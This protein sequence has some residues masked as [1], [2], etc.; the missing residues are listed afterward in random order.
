MSVRTIESVPTRLSASRPGSTQRAQPMMRMEIGSPW[1]GRQSPCS[2]TEE[3]TFVAELEAASI[4]QV[5]DE[6]ERRDA[7]VLLTSLR[8]GLTLKMLLA[9]APGV[10]PD[11]LLAAHRE[12]DGRR[13]LAAHA[14]QTI[15]VD[16]TVPTFTTFASCAAEL[17]PAL[18]S[19]LMAYEHDTARLEAAID[20][21]ADQVNRTSRRVLIL[22]RRLAESAGD[23]QRATE[24]GTL[25][26]DLYGQG[27]WSLPTYLPPRV[28]TLVPLRVGALLGDDISGQRRG[29]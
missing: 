15:I 6:F 13:L 20:D 5:V 8:S 22:E 25:L 21:A 24:L 3:S 18:I 7:T 23:P 29:T 19:H 16:R 26:Y 17:M 28:G 9:Q 27:A 14:W 2:A 4:G 12:L 10:K 11:R 1:V